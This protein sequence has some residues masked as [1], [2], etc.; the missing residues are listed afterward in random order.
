MIRGAVEQVMSNRVSGWIY[1]P[2]TDLKG[3]TLLAFVDDVCVGAGKVNIL[4]QDLA[5][6]GLGDGRFGYSFPVALSRPTDGM[7]LVVKLDGS[8]AMLKQNASRVQGAPL[9]AAKAPTGALALPPPVLHWMRGRGWLGQSEYDFLRY[10][11]QL[12][13]YDRTLT[14]PVER[15]DRVEVEL[16]DEAQ[17]VAD[18]LGLVCMREPKLERVTVP[19]A[20]DIA[21]LREKKGGHGD[22]PPI[23]ALWARERARLDVVEGSHLQEATTDASPAVE[24]TLGPDR[25]LILDTRCTLRLDAAAPPSG[26]DVF[27]IS[28]A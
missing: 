2:V 12:G 26:I 3:S 21:A 14:V 24:Y 4:R 19:G 22:A 1:S 16:R 6:A 27:L 10:F 23:V 20:G 17:A 15:P 5:D 8:D 18:I 28:E 25:L 9:A 13:I 11:S 7:R